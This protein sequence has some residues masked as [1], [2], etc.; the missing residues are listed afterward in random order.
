MLSTFGLLLTL[1]LNGVEFL[2]FKMEY[3]STKV[4]QHDFAANRYIK[5]DGLRLNI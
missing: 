2:A 4:R 5:F 1:E 3:V